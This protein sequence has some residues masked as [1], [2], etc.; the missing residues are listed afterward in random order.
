MG[1][2][3]RVI[4]LFI[5]MLSFG[6][7]NYPEDNIAKQVKL[8]LPDLTDSWHGSD[9]LAFGVLVVAGIANGASEAYEADRH[10]FEKRWGVSEQSWWGSKSWKRKY[11]NYDLGDE[12]AAFWQSKGALSVF[13]D[14]DH[15]S[16]GMQA[17]SL[18]GGFLII[19]LN[20]GKRKYKWWV[21]GSRFLTGFVGYTLSSSITYNLLR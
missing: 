8:S 3:I 10:I 7:F 12:R 19:G 15:F 14:F 18:S 6:Q 5:P 4:L 21:H 9:Y 11:K 1:N 2:F 13:T 20:G 17:V 16:E